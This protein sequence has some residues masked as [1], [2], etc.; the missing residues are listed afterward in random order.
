M[1]HLLRRTCEA[2]AMILH[3]SLSGCAVAM[4]GNVGAEQGRVLADDPPHYFV[5]SL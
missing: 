2:V 3:P 1:S 4:S 5:S